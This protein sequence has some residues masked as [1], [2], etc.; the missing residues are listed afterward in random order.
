MKL[1]QVNLK[2]TLPHD[3]YHKR[4]KHLQLELVGLERKLIDEK[5]PV[6]VMFEGW[7]ASGKGGA[8]KRFTQYLDPRGISAYSIAAPTVEEKSH[9]YLWRF[10]T[11]MPRHGELAI[12]DRSWYGRVL[13]ERVENFA[14]KD[15]WRRAYREINELER[16]LTDDGAVVLKFFIHISEKEQL[17]RFKEREE[18]KLKNWKLTEEDWRNRKRWQKYEKAIDDML[19][20][21]STKN[22]PWHVIPGNDKKYARVEVC[23]IIDKALKSAV[24]KA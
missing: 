20:K 4:L 21:T 10:W 18:S 13:V 14:T 17:R 5:V 1:S 22:A 8:I 11:K 23:R 16:Q 15:E 9:H 19:T 12:F 3:T 7:D 2:A 24:K 6:I